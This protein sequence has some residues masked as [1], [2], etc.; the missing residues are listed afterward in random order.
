MAKKSTYE[1]AA[2]E[3][4]KDLRAVMS[5]FGDVNFM[6]DDSSPKTKARREMLAS[7]SP[8]LQQM[9]QDGMPMYV[10]E[11]LARMDVD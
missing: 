5:S 4:S 2:R 3:A 1:L 6:R 9:Q 11:K 8:D 7:M 10:L